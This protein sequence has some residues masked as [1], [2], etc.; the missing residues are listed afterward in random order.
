MWHAEG[1]EEKSF[2]MW[3]PEQNT[4]LESNL[5]RYEDSIKTGRKEIGC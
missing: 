2:S 3:K 4:R 1:W 5:H